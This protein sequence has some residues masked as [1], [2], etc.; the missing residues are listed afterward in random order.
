MT[1]KVQKL[2]DWQPT[3]EE[4]TNLAN[5]MRDIDEWYKYRSY[6]ED[7]WVR[8]QQKWNQINKVENSIH[9][10]L[11]RM[12]TQTGIIMMSQ[13]PFKIGIIPENPDDNAIVDIIKDLN[14]HYDRLNGM[15]EVYAQ[16]LTDY[17]VLGNGVIEDYVQFPYV[18]HRKKV[19]GKWEDHYVRD[20]SRAKIASRAR[21]PWECA[22][23]PGSRTVTD[24]RACT[25]T[26]IIDIN[27]FKEIYNNGKT[28]MYINVEYV[29]GGIAWI[30]DPHAREFKHIEQNNKL[31]AIQHYQDE[32]T[33]VYRIYANGILIM[34]ESLRSFHK[35]GKITLSLLTNHHT[36]DDD[37]RRHRLYGKGDP[38]LL[39]D[40]DDLLNAVMNQF[41]R[42]YEKKNTNIISITGAPSIEEI[43][44]SGDEVIPGD[45]KV[46]SL[47]QASLNEFNA[48]KDIIEQFAIQ[49]ARKN[50]KRLEGEVAKTAY[51]AKQ[52]QRSENMGIAYQVR[53]IENVGLRAHFQKRI[54]DMME[55][56]TQEE[57]IEISDMSI[58]DAEVFKSLYKDSIRSMDEKGT[59][60]TFAFRESFKTKGR[61]YEMGVS[62]RNKLKMLS[63][64]EDGMLTAYPEFIQTR[65]FKIFGR[66]PEVYVVSGSSLFEDNEI[67]SEGLSKAF[68][69]SQA[70]EAMKLQFPDST[71]KWE[72]YEEKILRYADINPEEILEQKDETIAKQEKIVQD[73]GDVL[74]D[75]PTTQAIS[76]LGQG[77]I[78][79]N[80]ESGSG[81][82][83][84]PIQPASTPMA[85]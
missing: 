66:I 10:P 26:D 22:F 23:K 56:S 79:G 16:V 34:D 15:P 2:L 84:G 74:A 38:F 42:N 78:Q 24:V 25:F 81:P 6:E 53:N 80:E 28:D 14:D 70:V 32:L 62:E 44:L 52:K 27:E 18:N 77:Q 4:L 71:K 58:Q 7:G 20:F 55:F 35:H 73:M 8:A 60:L 69:V 59:P 11:S 85:R 30:F 46:Q 83:T 21:S 76:S 67:K 57:I 47:G 5:D 61:S 1:E 75:N 33:D 17:A 64:T 51:E 49:H 29:E 40:L 65:E 31:V 50:Y 37:L 72:M 13:N 43:N 48:F 12:I 63:E 45:V 41:V 39:E 82:V 9:I 19:N 54:S 68:S 3:E 36:Y